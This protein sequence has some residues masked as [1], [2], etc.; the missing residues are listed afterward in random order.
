MKDKKIP[1][2]SLIREKYS[3]HIINEIENMIDLRKFFWT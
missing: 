2:I 1:Y 3:L